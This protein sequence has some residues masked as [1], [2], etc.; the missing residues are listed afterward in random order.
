MDSDKKK[1][2]LILSDSDRMFRRVRRLLKEKDYYEIIHTT[3]FDEAYPMVCEDR[4]DFVFYDV[5][6]ALDEGVRKLDMMK[7][8]NSRIPVVVS[9]VLDHP[10]PGKGGRPPRG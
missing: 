1:K 9:A 7:G 4:V 2:I 10:P 5:N 8:A 3:S 6:F